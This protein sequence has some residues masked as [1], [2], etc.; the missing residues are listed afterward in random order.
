MKLGGRPSSEVTSPMPE[1]PSPGT[2]SISYYEWSWAESPA[3]KWR[4]QCRWPEGPAFKR[5]V[6][7][8]S[9]KSNVPAPK[10]SNK[11]NFLLEWS[12]AEGPASKRQVLCWSNKANV[13]HLVPG[14]GCSGI[15]LVILKARYFHQYYL[16]SWNYWFFGLR[17]NHHNNPQIIGFLV[18][19]RTNQPNLKLLVKIE[20]LGEDFGPLLA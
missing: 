7:C 1:Q 19:S 9:N 12:W 11:H 5:Q 14:L 16:N 6:Q 8:W 2:I 20:P 18:L 4:V 17:N 15:G 13:F 3:S 10:S